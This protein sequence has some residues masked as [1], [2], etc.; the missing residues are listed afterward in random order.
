MCVQFSSE[1]LLCK[2][3]SWVAKNEEQHTTTLNEEKKAPLF[4]TNDDEAIINVNE[5][6][7]FS[8]RLVYFSFPLEM[9]FLGKFQNH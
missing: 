8:Q 4:K 6:G 7:H 3:L 2:Y 1:L 9:V 5:R